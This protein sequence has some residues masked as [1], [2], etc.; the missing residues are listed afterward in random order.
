[1]QKIVESK[2]QLKREVKIIVFNPKYILTED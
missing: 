1:M 2:L